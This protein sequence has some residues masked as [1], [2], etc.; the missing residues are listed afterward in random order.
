[1]S[2]MM[3]YFNSDSFTISIMKMLKKTNIPG[4]TVAIVHNKATTSA[5]F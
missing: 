2:K 4:L 5:A 3:D 1:M